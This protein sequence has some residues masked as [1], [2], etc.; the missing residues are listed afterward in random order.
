MTVIGVIVGSI[1]GVI[2]LYF[3]SYFLGIFHVFATAVWTFTFLELTTEEEKLDLRK[4]VRKDIDIREEMKKK[5]PVQDEGVSS[6]DEDGESSGSDQLADQ[7]E[8]VD[9]ENEDV[10]KGEGPDSL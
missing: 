3:A 6:G 10:N 7:E 1:V 4:A 8:V 9:E 5:S 2:A